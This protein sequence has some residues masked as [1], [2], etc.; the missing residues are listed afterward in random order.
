MTVVRMRELLQPMGQNPGTIEGRQQ[1]VLSVYSLNNLPLNGFSASRQGYSKY[2]DP[3]DSKRKSE[4]GKSLLEMFHKTYHT[5]ED[6]R[7]Q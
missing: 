5:A 4:G 1:R 6:P 3:M 2:P 7:I